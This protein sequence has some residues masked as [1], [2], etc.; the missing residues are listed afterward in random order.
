[1]SMFDTGLPGVSF[2]PGQ[3]GTAQQNGNGNGA[4][5]AGNSVQEAIKILSLRLPKVVGA[6]GVAPQRLLESMGSGGNPQI[7]SVLTR[8][9]QKIFPNAVPTSPIDFSYMGG[10]DPGASSTP[11]YS[12]PQYQTEQRTPWR[13]PQG[14]DPRV[15]V[16]GPLAPRWPN[17]AG[18]DGGGGFP[19]ASIIEPAPRLDTSQFETPSPQP[20]PPQRSSAPSAPPPGDVMAWSPYEI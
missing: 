12:Q 10:S 16:G 4:P 13:P 18:V 19:P 17:Q 9:W 20:Q 1:M 6:Q 7:D 11:S 15:I 14:F 8:V 3:G 5:N 2:Q